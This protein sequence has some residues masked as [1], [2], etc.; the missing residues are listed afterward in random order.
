LLFG[1]RE[2]SQ[3]VI[4][5]NTIYMLN[6][7]V[8]SSRDGLHWTKVTDR[9]VGEEI[10]GYAPTVYDNSIWLIGC[11][12]DGKF[13]NQVLTSKDG[14][15]WTTQDAPW[16]PR[17]AAAVCLYQGKLFMTGGKYGGLVENGNTTEFIY[18]NDVWTLGKD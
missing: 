12:R 4:F 17:G 10:F 11:N 5:N 3:F 9:I 8:W 1:K 6:N 14:K 13:Q 16:S 18:S 2:N 15:A 7:D